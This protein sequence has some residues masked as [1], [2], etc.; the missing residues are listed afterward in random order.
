MPYVKRAGKVWG[1]NCFLQGVMGK[2]RVRKSLQEEV[3]LELRGG[4]K[5][6]RETLR[7]GMEAAEA[8]PLPR[9]SRRC[10]NGVYVGESRGWQQALLEASLDWRC[11]GRTRAKVRFIVTLST[12]PPGNHDLHSLKTNYNQDCSAVRNSENLSLAAWWVEQKGTSSSELS[13][14]KKWGAQGLAHRWDQGNKEKPSGAL[15]N[16]RSISADPRPPKV[17]ERCEVR[18]PLP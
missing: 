15:A 1:Q 4:W 2:G 3:A 10:A 18:D 7:A 13:P 14:Q 11:S 16:S 12:L 6:K 17:G 8:A 5:G 9:G